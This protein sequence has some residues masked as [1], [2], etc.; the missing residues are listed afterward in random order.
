M[1]MSAGALWVPC[2]PQMLAAGLGDSLDDALRYLKAVTF[3]EVDEQRLSAFVTGAVRMVEWL[4]DN[5]KVT[6]STLVHYPDYNSAV[7]GARDGGRSLEPDAFDARA[8]GDEF[9]TLHRP[10][11]GTLILGKFLMRI[12]EARDLLM[13]GL[14]PKLGLARG[15][16]RYLA[17]S[18]ARRA[19]GRDPY[20]TMGQALAGRLRLSLLERGVPLWTSS[21]VVSLVTDEGRVTGAVVEREGSKVRIEARAGVLVASGGFERNAALRQRYQRSP[22]GAEWTVGHEGNTGDGL[23]LGEEVGAALDVELM[24]EAWWTPAVVPPEGG[25]S[26]LVI[27]KSLPHGIFV[28]RQGHRFV[29]EAASYNDVGN[30]LYDAEGD[31]RG[32]VPA[33]WVLDATYRKRFIIGPVGPGFMMPDKKLPHALRPGNGWL[34]KA[35]TLDELAAQI[36]VDAKALGATI[37]RFNEHAARGEDP[38]FQRGATANDRY[39]SD[40]RVGP[41]PSLG[42]VATPPFYAVAIYPGD[43]GTKAGLMTDASGR[44]RR[45]DGTTITGLFAAGNT[46]STVMGRAY[47]GAGATLAPA[48]LGGF[49][50]AEAIAAEHGSP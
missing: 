34:H 46:A 17:R 41:N 36:D 14:R 23:R 3:G 15:F 11:P 10:Y 8:L 45:A 22:T 50:A 25:P 37:A 43:L 31:G 4:R 28:D 21:A 2:N 38:D 29:N 7:D 1:A 13:P 18:R 16:A 33:W 47:P 12:P 44:M 19:L 24:R 32:G 35:D 30:A 26:V 42:P 39:Y 5:S 40:P 27:E 48:M 6:F 9:R 20:L 49:V